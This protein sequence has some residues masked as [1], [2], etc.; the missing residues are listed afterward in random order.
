MVIQINNEVAV[1]V[2]NVAA[3]M[4]NTRNAE[5]PSVQVM[6]TNNQGTVLVPFP[7][8][9]AARQE[10]N[11]AVQTLIEATSNAA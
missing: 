6:L 3:I 9:E 1:P 11:I 10:Y 5:I 2:Q 7:D 4:L 8:E